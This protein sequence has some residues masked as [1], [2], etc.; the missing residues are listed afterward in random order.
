MTQQIQKIFQSQ[1]NQ[2]NWKQFLD[3]AFAD[4]RLL[5][6]PKTLTGIN[7]DVAIQ[8]VQLGRIVLNEN[9][10]KPQVQ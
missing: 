5:L 2:N 1:Y 9:S 3:K 8:A 7:S 10:I 4:A 6:K